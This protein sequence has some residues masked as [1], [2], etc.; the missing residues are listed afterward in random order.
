MKLSHRLSSSS[1]ATQA[2]TGKI[3][4]HGLDQDFGINES[5]TNVSRQRIQREMKCK[6]Q[7]AV[8]SVQLASWADR[9]GKETWN[10]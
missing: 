5:K 8:E 7:L 6:A 3:P 1:P 2:P 9:E 4:L 10:Y